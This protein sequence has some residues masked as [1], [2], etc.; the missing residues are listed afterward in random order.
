MQSVEPEESFKNSWAD[1]LMASLAMDDFLW[2]SENIDWFLTF[3]ILFIITLKICRQDVI[4]YD[5]CFKKEMEFYS[6][7]QKYRKLPSYINIII[8][9]LQ[10]NVIYFC[11]I[12][13]YL[14]GYI[15]SNIDK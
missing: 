7:A 9:K 3:L 8:H 14:K 11:C 4:I 6:K 13:M 15:F 2:V 1:K 10:L 5:K 12:R